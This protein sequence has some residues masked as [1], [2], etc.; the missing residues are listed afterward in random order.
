VVY[1][2]FFLHSIP[3]AVQETIFDA[4]SDVLPGGFV[5]ALEF[6]TD[7]DADQRKTYGDH[8]RR[9]IDPREVV[10]SLS[11]RGY[12]IE[13]EHAG[14]GLSPYGDEDPHLARILARKAR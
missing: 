6:R 2:R 14:T 7:K 12:A 3:K 13:F 1:M 11:R 4:V 10:D 5:M 8:Y 9:F